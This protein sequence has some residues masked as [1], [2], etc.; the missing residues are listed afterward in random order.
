MFKIKKVINDEMDM[1]TYLLIK[2]KSM[3]IID[4][5]FNGA[6]VLDIIKKDELLI[7][8]VFLTL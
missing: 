1:N 3:I 6:K 5:G 2:Q 7:E 8:A 4:P